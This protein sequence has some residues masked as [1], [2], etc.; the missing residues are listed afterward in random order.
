MKFLRPAAFA[1]L[2][3][4][5][6]P[7]CLQQ[8]KVIKLKTDG[9][10]TVEE[11]MVMSKEVIAQMKQM[12]EGFGSLLQGKGKADAT[13]ASPFQIMDEKKL[14]E[15]AEKMGEGV[16]FVSATPVTTATGEGFKAIYAFTDINTLKIDQNPG[17]NM[18]GAD[19]P[20]MQKANKTKKEP[21]K[22]EFTKG[23]PASLTV[24]LPQPKTSD[25]PKDRPAVPAGGQ[26]MAG[27][28]MQQMFKD[29]KIS[30]AIEVAGRIVQTN[31]EYKDATRVTLMEMDF[32]KV[33]ANP[34]KFKALTA[35]Q[36][37][38]IEEAKA[39]VKGVDGIKAETQPTVTMK[40]Q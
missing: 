11:T 35:A 37:K 33:L 36:P 12:T 7:G 21:V 32:N 40:F 23:S 1:F 10:G 29:M 16:T 22:F 9:S 25:L 18:P 5:L 26:D 19:N 15:A 28:M 4:L 17:G 6:L 38:T 3:M 20:L 13:P 24:K 14:R 8:E 39:L 31:A 34:E 27:M 2:T 30:L